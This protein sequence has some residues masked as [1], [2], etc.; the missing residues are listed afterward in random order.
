MAKTEKGTKTQARKDNFLGLLSEKTVDNE[1]NAE[2]NNFFIG[3]TTFNFAGKTLLFPDNLFMDSRNRTK[4]ENAIG[5]KGR[6]GEK[7]NIIIRDGRELDG[8]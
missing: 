5:I 1:N 8:D 3:A 2:E 6:M 7:I 4:P